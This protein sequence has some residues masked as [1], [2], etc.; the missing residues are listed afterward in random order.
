ML[1]WKLNIGWKLNNGWM[2]NDHMKHI[3]ANLS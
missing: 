1:G 2:E 3:S